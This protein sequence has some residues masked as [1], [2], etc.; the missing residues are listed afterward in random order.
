VH[1]ENMTRFARAR[2]VGDA[3]SR[4]ALD[5]IADSVPRRRRPSRA[6]VVN[7]DAVERA[8][9]VEAFID[10]PV[11]SAEPWRTSTRRRSIGRSTFWPRDAAIDEVR[12]DGAAGRVPGARRGARRQPRH[13]PLRDA[14]GAERRRLHVLWWAQSL[15]PCGYAAFDL[16][17]A[18][19]RHTG[20]AAPPAYASSYGGA[21]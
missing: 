20:R 16:R 2:Q 21:W 18:A 6:V 15:P 13:E 5:A 12:P 10:L 17:S 14:V 11:D 3:S 7:R 19:A 1:E 8:Q 4:R 9:V